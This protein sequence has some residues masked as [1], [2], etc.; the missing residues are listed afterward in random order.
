MLAVIPG[1][2][3]IDGTL[4]NAGHAAA[5]L[6]SAGVKG[7]LLGI[8]RDSS[9]LARASTR[10]AHHAGAVFAHGN[11]ADLTEIAISNGF[12]KVQ[13]VLLDLGVSSNQLDTPERGFSYQH[14]GPLDMRMDTSSGITAA[15]LLAESD[16]SSLAKI[17]RSFGEE[18][19][20][21]SIAKAIIRAREKAPI[22]TTE[23]LVTIVGSIAAKLPPHVRRQTQ[24]RVF[25]ALRMAVNREL[26]ALENAL[27]AGLKLL[28]QNGRMVVISFESLTD[29]IVKQCFAT[30]VGR[31]RALPQGGTEWEGK[32]P[33][34]AL[35][36]RRPQLPGEEEIK[37]NTRARSAKLRGARRLTSEEEEIFL[38]RKNYTKESMA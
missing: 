4:G 2:S 29:R 37:Q 25:Q 35:L 33:I 34:V 38:M 3:Y 30:H 14:N 13:G 32:L 31:M 26:E 15:E 6:Q 20:S 24:T 28:A 7:R 21:L 18:P 16:V 11:H 1:G 12:E 36:N 9:A 10:L 8:D 19:R 5:I 27:E 17:L 23:Q 22:E